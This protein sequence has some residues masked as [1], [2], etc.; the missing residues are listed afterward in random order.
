MARFGQQFIQGLLQPSY[1]QG[2]FGLGSQVGQGPALKAERQKSQGM[3]AQ[4]QEAINSGDLDTASKLMIQTPGYEKA[5]L[6]LANT[7]RQASVTQED[8][9]KGRG[10]QGGLMAITQAAARGVKLEDLQEAQQ[11]VINLGG[12][13][14][15]IMQAYNQG[16]E[17]TAPGEKYKVVGNRVFDI[18]TGTYVEPKEAAKLMS[19][20]DLA[21]VAKPES[22]V[23]YLKSGDPNDL[24]AL[25]ERKGQ[26]TEQVT[27]RLLSADNTLTTIKEAAGLAGEIYPVFYDL[28]KVAPYTDARALNGK[29]STLKSV[30]SFDRLQKMRDESKTGGA[31]GNVSNI[32]LD[33]LGSNVATLDPA[34]KDF[35]TQLEKVER[36]YANFKASL[37]GEKP[38]DDRYIEDNGILY[39]VTDDG[40]FKPLGEL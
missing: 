10:I 11:S 25:E 28:A 38:Q 35:A 22:I 5:G 7:A 13:T 21:K 9:A 23:K 14:E 26:T 27:S 3:L 18:T 16:V 2:L 33:L 12:T 36:A 15:D 39:Y 32:E 31:L 6:D 8:K 30:L 4:I 37:L 34:S 24:E 20:N 1:Q 17:S 29:I 40:D 19:A